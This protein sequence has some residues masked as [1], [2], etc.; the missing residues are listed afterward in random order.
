MT[1]NNSILFRVEELWLVTSGSFPPYITRVWRVLPTWP[2]HLSLFYNLIS[3]SLSLSLTLS[4]S[5]SPS[6]S[7]RSSIS[8][9]ICLSLSL[10]LPLC[11]GSLDRLHSDYPLGH[12]SSNYLL[13][14][15]STHISL[16]PSSTHISLSLIQSYISPILPSL[17]HLSKS[18]SHHLS[19]QYIRHYYSVANNIPLFSETQ[20]PICVKH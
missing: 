16:S 9:C 20:C 12:N 13:L 2:F 1:D 7:F 8:I 15:S 5:L 19:N 11:P 17:F 14:P 18:S 3:L 4:L 6:H 10:S